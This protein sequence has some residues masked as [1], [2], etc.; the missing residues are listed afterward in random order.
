MASGVVFSERWENRSMRSSTIAMLSGIMM[1]LSFG[2]A[3]QAQS[4]NTRI[5]SMPFDECLAIIP[6]DAGAPSDQSTSSAM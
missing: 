6:A 4:A 5:A 3:A 2:S 1:A